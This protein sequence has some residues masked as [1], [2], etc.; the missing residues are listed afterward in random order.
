MLFS[1]VKEP[2]GS[3]LRSP[4]ECRSGTSRP[5]RRTNAHAQTFYTRHRETSTM[6]GSRMG[7]SFFQTPVC[8]RSRN[9]S[10][11]MTNLNTLTKCCTRWNQGAAGR[12]GKHKTT[13]H[14][15]KD[16]RCAFRKLSTLAIRSSGG[17]TQ[18]HSSAKLASNRGSLGHL[19]RGIPVQG[20]LRKLV[21]HIRE[22]TLTQRAI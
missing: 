11:P 5:W 3:F 7:G 6:H 21:Q 12:S 1:K 14:S 4:K 22:E 13:R 17:N 18:M 9:K 20:D 15:T 2:K 10:D 8:P 16:R 19:Y